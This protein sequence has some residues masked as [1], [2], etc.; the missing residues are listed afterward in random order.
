MFTPR[1]EAVNRGGVC[2]DY[3]R[4]RA[5][6]LGISASHTVIRDTTPCDHPVSFFAY[7]YIDL[8]LVSSDVTGR[9]V[10]ATSA[11]TPIPTFVA[12]SHAISTALVGVIEGAWAV[13]SSTARSTPRNAHLCALT[14][15]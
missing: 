14:Y 3:D 4:S 7:F 11:R 12:T 6:F 15:V 13:E 1:F 2:D 8:S 10:R 9:R 5:M